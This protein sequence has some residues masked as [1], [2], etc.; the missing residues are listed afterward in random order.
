MSHTR[1]SSHRS[2]SRSSRRMVVMSIGLGLALTLGVADAALAAIPEP[3]FTSK[4]KDEYGP[5]ASS[6]YLVWTRGLVGRFGH[7]NTYAKRA[8]Q[9][10][11]RLN[12]PRSASYG[13]AVYGSTVLYEQT[14]RNQDGD[15]KLYHLG[16]GTRTNP[17]PGVN[18]KHDEDQPGISGNYLFFTRRNFDQN[19]GALI[20]YDRT[21]ETSRVLATARPRH[22]YLISNQVNGDWAVWEKCKF[23][24]SGGYSNCNVFRY[25]ISTK[26][27]VRLPNP[28]KQQYGSA[29][30][31][32]GT[33]YF[34]VGGRS[35]YWHCGTNAK[36]VRYPIGG[37]RTVIASLP[38]GK[39]AFSMFA[40]E[41]GAS[42]VTLYFDRTN[43]RLDQDIYKLSNAESA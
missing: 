31:S 24:S 14:P 39:D 36:L 20:L 18:T 19:T 23:D 37:P 35:D 9:P 6:S 42:A 15:L 25:R 22:H 3:L 11:I 26:Q 32:D 2:P 33:V 27:T 41:E 43:C 16:A 13:A 28:G 17:G 1:G 5:T 38:N 7:Y 21:T 34:V 4:A 40:F 12:E 10:R 30:T 29:V 8:G